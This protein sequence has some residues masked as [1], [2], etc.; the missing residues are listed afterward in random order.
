MRSRQSRGVGSAQIG[1]L[2]AGRTERVGTSRPHVLV[3]AAGSPEFLRRPSRAA[4]CGAAAAGREGSARRWIGAR[5]CRVLGPPGWIGCGRRRTETRRG[6]QRGR[7]SSGARKLSRSGPMT[8]SAVTGPVIGRWFRHLPQ[9]RAC[10]VER[11]C[12]WAA[13]RP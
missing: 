2:P 5:R 11:V 4:F 8:R 9:C 10:T 12:V 7:A 6:A 1:C 13:E 3:A